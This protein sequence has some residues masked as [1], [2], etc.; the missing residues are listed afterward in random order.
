MA[1]RI[2]ATMRRNMDNKHNQAKAI[3]R[4][5]HN[6]ARAMGSSLTINMVGRIA[7]ILLRD[8]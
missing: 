6:K 8:R 4:T 5:T 7:H 3:I 2:M 1:S